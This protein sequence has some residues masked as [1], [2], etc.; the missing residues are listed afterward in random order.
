MARRIRK[1]S[2]APVERIGFPHTPDP[3]ILRILG[4][5]L[6]QDVVEESAILDA[7]FPHA[8]KSIGELASGAD[9]GKRVHLKGAALSTGNANP[10]LYR[11]SSVR[12]RA[13]A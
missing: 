4:E 12:I 13:V 9:R 1:L 8:S 7:K 11:C 10:I 6:A 3:K 2:I 5:G